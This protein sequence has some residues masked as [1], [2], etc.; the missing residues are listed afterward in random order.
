MYNLEYLEL[1]IRIVIGNE[2]LM[3]ESNPGIWTSPFTVTSQMRCQG[4]IDRVR[5]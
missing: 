4:M 5:D 1:R 3:G 2:W